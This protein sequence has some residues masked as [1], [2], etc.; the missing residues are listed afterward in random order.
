MSAGV[1][2]TDLF[3]YWLC[4]LMLFSLAFEPCE[5]LGV[6]EDDSHGWP[7]GHMHSP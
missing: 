5:C 4:Q 2:R 1:S 3:T 6:T 7:V